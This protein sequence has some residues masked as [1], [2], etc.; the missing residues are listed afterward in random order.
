MRVPFLDKKVVD[1]ASKIPTDM[2]IA[3]NTKK[4]VL[5]KAA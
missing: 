1:T 2:R 3:Q 4:D 5:R